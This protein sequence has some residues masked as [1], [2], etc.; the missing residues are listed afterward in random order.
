MCSQYTEEYRT[1][2]QADRQDM[3]EHHDYMK[4]YQA[5][6]IVWT[7]E[8]MRFCQCRRHLEFDC[9]ATWKTANRTVTVEDSFQGIFV[10]LCYTLW[11]VWDIRAAV[12]KRHRHGAGIINVVEDRVWYTASESNPIVE[13]IEFLIPGLG[14][15]TE[16]VVIY[17]TTS[18]LICAPWL[19]WL[20]RTTVS[21]HQLRWETKS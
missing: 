20:K 1:K 21:N 4:A 12:R 6:H 2:L 16:H 7:D 3:K 10:S 15:E 8:V 19:S 9:C 13:A 11:F 17:A 18:Q 5:F 14:G